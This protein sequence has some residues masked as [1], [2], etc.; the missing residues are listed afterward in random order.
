V[1][2]DAGVRI[3]LLG[4]FDVTVAGRPV[5]AAAWRLRK[6]KTLVKLLALAGGHRMHREAL[7]AVLWPDRD[8]E[9]AAN[10]LHQALYVAR[11]A[12]GGASGGLFTLRDGV[13]LLSDGAVP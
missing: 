4:G 8:G 5:A 6:A 2:D 11:R 9:A 12:L 3:R 10:N 7:V 13:V 1:A